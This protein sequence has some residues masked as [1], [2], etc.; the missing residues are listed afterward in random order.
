M[1]STDIID[2]FR[3]KLTV[4]GGRHLYGVLGTYAQLTAFAKELSQAKTPDGKKFPAPI[5]VNKG[6]LDTIP[7][8]DFKELVQNEARRPEPTRANVGIAFEKFL[9]ER[10]QKKGLI[11]LANLEM[12][13]A[14]QLEL[15]LLR[16]MA[17]DED[18]IV[19]LLPGRRDGGKVVMFPDWPDGSYQL[20]TN[21]IADNHLWELR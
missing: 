4:P 12:L 21:L 7:D 20:P 14:Y 1:K 6:I 8:A 11:V 5:N 16:T 17:A 3:S 2:A 13:F 19:L 18:R 15:N 9:R 10:L